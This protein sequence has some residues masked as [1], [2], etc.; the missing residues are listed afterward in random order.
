MRRDKFLAA[1]QS[2]L[3]PVVPEGKV[4]NL[5]R[6]ERPGVPQSRTTILA[7]R[8]KK[9]GIVC[10]A[11][12]KT[13]GWGYNILSQESRKIYDVSGT[14]VM[15]GSGIVGFIQEVRDSLA[16]RNGSFLRSYGLP[17]SVQGQA[18]LLSRWCHWFRRVDGGDFSF[19]AILAGTNVE[20]DS[21]IISIEEDGS[22]I[23]FPDYFA[24]GS[25]GDGATVL[26]DAHWKPHLEESAAVELAVEAVYHAA[27]RDSG[28][29]D[30]RVATPT[31]ALVKP[32]GIVFLSEE[33][34]RS[35]SLVV[36][37]KKM[38]LPK[39]GSPEFPVSR[40]DRVADVHR[41]PE[42]LPRGKRAR[43]RKRRSR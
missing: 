12:R 9:D 42:D 38:G 11:D 29:S 25:G 22:R 24:T 32:E 28:S 36:L 40:D 20:G 27:F 10:A 13:S 14:T 41:E 30:I 26:L 17:I 3:P 15:L 8:Y 2:V 7:L 16:T 1:A 21:H 6:S 18:K 5:G 19:G 31:V 34:I 35:L 4:L 23:E 33:A 37:T 39:P 43:M